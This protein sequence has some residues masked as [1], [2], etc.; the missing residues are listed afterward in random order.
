M[1]SYPSKP[2]AFR[3]FVS[4]RRR[5][6]L[7]TSTKVQTKKKR[8]CAPTQI[9]KNKIIPI[10]NF[11]SREKENFMRQFTLPQ[12]TRVY[13]R[14]IIPPHERCMQPLGCCVTAWPKHH[15]T[16]QGAPKWPKQRHPAPPNPP[17]DQA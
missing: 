13:H 3:L 5:L 4:P 9:K 1:E 2:A 10:R 14:Y 15:W 17:P 12:T 11:R 8:S 6:V 7:M 16:S